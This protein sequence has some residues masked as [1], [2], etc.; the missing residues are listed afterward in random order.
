MK[1]RRLATLALTALAALGLLML[2]PTMLGYQRY[3]I[4]GGS[5]GDGL[6]R[7][8]I[9]YEE[10]VPTGQIRVGDV[11]TYRP[12]GATS[13]RT[14]RVVWIGHAGA[15]SRGGTGPGTGTTP[16]PGPATA[17]RL[18]RTRGDANPTNDHPAFTLPHPTQARVVMHVPLAGYA[19]T[20]L[21]IR[22]VRMAVI[23]GPALVIACVAF[24]AVWRERPRGSTPVFG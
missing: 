13:L 18:Y 21:S 14:H 8:S 16:A 9:A 6:P 5:M 12:P 10:V 1:R 7:G 20:A 15:G 4:E 19:V 11:I 3:V 23:G 22:A 2:V 17:T 24:A